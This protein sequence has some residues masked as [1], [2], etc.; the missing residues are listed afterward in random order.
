VRIRDVM[1]TRV[2]TISAEAPACEAVEKLIEF[3]IG[4]LPVIGDEGQLV[5]IVT[6]SDL[7]QVAYRVMAGK[8]TA[9]HEQ[10]LL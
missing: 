9:A 10:Q 4:C 2:H 1:T 7:L 3:K 5:G 6:E 8:R